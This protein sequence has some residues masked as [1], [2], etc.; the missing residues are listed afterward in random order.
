MSDNLFQ[1]L[2]FEGEICLLLSSCIRQDWLVEH[3][4]SRDVP[5]QRPTQNVNLGDCLI[6]SKQDA[7]IS[8]K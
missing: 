5:F 8:L 1:L 7:K 6:R 2:K 3:L 4:L